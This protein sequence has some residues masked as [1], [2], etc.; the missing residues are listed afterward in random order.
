MAASQKVKKKR[1]ITL[2]WKYDATLNIK[3]NER[4]F[5]SL[6]ASLQSTVS[7]ECF[8]LIRTANA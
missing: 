4:V 2:N 3:V 8:K 1:G 5:V 7:C 6:I